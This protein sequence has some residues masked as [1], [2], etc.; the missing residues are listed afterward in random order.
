LKARGFSGLLSGMTVEQ[1]AREIGA[2]LAGD[3]SPT[4]LSAATLEDAQPGQIGFLAN[5]K[6]TRQLEATRASAVIVATSVSHPRITLLKSADPYFAFRKA[7]ILLHGFRRHPFAGIHPGAHVDPGATVGE[8]SI[9][10]PGAYVGPRSR[11]GRNCILYPNAV[12]YDGCVIGDRVI[13]HAGA[14][15]GADGYG[16]ATHQGEHHKIPQV[17]N[18]IIEDD[19]EIGA[20]CSIERAALGS[21]IIGRGT[22]IDQLVVIGHGVRVG[23][24]CLLVA[25]TGIAGSATLG[26]HVTLAGQTGVSGHLKIGNNV[27][28]GAQSGVISDI[29][30]QATLVGSPAMPVSH[31]R[32]VYMHFTQLPD[33]VERIKSLEQQVEELSSNDAAGDSEIV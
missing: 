15:I 13:I 25:Q 26:H 27:T 10:Y 7:V 20:C 12:I 29:D 9:V 3:G 17:G 2:E 22:K 21:T 33:L 5:A 14:A 6:Y 8:G 1:L 32:R 18:V 28:V 16:F 19:V 11:V 30:D 24:H 31:A 23:P 4:V